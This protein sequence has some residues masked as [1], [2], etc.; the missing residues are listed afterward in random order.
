MRLEWLGH[1]SFL[2]EGS[3]RI[4]IDPFR[5][6][7]GAPAD[8]IFITHTHQDHLDPA[9][10]VH[11]STNDTTIVC[12]ADSVERLEGLDH[13]AIIA[14]QPGEQLE[15]GGVHVQ[16]THAYNTNKEFHPEDN[17]WLGFLI[18]IDDTTIFHTGDI[19]DLEELHG[20]S[21][22]VLLVPVSGTYVMTAEEA[23]RFA[24]QLTYD[25]AVPM[26]FGSIVGTVED[27]E[28]FVSL[29]ENAVVPEKDVDLLEGL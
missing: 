11:L 28:R 23:A 19:D 10:L 9:S 25:R 8:I 1:A 7:S 27:A 29:A 17:G 18:S 20:L 12:S 24:K 6:P 5:I 2:I 26:H 21:C 14:M 22:D 3:Q 4:Y 16:A 13:K 15:S